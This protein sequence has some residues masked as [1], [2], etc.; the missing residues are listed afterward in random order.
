[1]TPPC[2]GRHRERSNATRNPAGAGPPGD[3]S[4]QL[5]QPLVGD[6]PGAGRPGKAGHGGDP[7]D[8]LRAAAETAGDL[9]VPDAVVNQPQHQSLDRPQ[10]WTLRHDRVS[11]W[12]AD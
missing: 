11:I 9:D 6:G 1:M 5:P 10:G 8:H 3:P 7:T 12:V 4:L 2:A